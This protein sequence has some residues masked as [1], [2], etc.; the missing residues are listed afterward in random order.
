MVDRLDP[1]CADQS[2]ARGDALAGTAAPTRGWLLIEQPGA[3]GPAALPVDGLEPDV[4]AEVLRRCAAVGV[5]P[6]LVRRPP[7]TT[8]PERRRW[9][10]V[11]PSGTPDAVRQGTWEH[12]ADL[13]DIAIETIVDPTAAAPGH[14][15]GEGP[16]RMFLVCAHG[17][18]DPC[19][20]T[21]GRALIR[22]V[23]DPLGEEL[24]ECSHLGGDRF[25]GN[26]LLLP[27]GYYFGRLRGDSEPVI[28]QVLDG[29]LPIDH[30]RGRATFSQFAQAAEIGARRALGDVD[31]APVTLV[32][33]ARQD[34]D[35]RT[36]VLR[37]HGEEVELVVTKSRPAPDAMLTCNATAPGRGIE[38]TVDIV[39][40]TPAGP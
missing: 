28:R 1:P 27:H 22:S 19:C 23:R 4:A 30:Y 12:D 9:F 6:L 20:A 18:H 38:F 10:T 40:R 7:R 21:Y 11:G 36:V 14:A 29:V 31:L 5:R 33:E 16:A 8:R 3:W 15:D 17:R 13:L 25:A 2:A 26:L 35:T 34:P 24:W 37:L 39:R 32:S